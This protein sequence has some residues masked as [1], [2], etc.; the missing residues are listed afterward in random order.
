METILISL[1]LRACAAT[2]T[3]ILTDLAVRQHSHS[4]AGLAAGCAIVTLSLML[5]TKTKI[6]VKR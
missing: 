5:E 4:L 1:W 2:P 3:M 6:T